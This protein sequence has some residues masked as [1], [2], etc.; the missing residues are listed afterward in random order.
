MR[1][2]TGINRLLLGL[3]V[4]GLLVALSSVA[5]SETSV[6]PGSKAAGLDS[7]VAPTAEMRRYHM[8]YLTHDRNET[9][10]AGKRG[11]KYSL[12]A[13]VDCHAAKDD[14]GEYVPVNAEG[15]FCEACHN[16]TAVEPVCFQCHRKV[17]E[18]KS[19]AL[20][21]V[22]AGNDDYA[23]GLL[24]QDGQVPSLSADEYA[25]VHAIV[26]GED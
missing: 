18:A 2:S 11:V 15:Q 23:L 9:V 14:K 8:L 21:A 3:L 5:L 4:G 25:R 24:M 26:E 17:P 13:C 6:A 12:S 19:S 10:R 1:S 22:K 7:C 20:G 16:Y